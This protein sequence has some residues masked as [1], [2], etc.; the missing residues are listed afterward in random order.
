MQRLDTEIYHQNQAINELSD[1]YSNR[2]RR[3]NV[4]GVEGRTDWATFWHFHNREGPKNFNA[5]LRVSITLAMNLSICNCG[6]L[7]CC[8]KKVYIIFIPIV[9]SLLWSCEDAF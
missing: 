5:V 6:N 8:V 2:G 4:T 9:Q 3:P 1:T 7:Q